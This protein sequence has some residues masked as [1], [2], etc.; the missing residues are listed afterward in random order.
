[1]NCIIIVQFT[2]W[3]VVS[4]S[5]MQAAKAIHSCSL[6]CVETDGCADGCIAIAVFAFHMP[7]SQLQTYLTAVVT[8][9]K[10]KQGTEDAAETSCKTVN[11]HQAYINTGRVHIVFLIL[12]TCQY[13]SAQ[14]IVHAAGL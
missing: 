10:N 11:F 13:V 4:V 1:M 14:P 8:V 7:L 6:W 3:H 5:L 2:A 12:M 9:V